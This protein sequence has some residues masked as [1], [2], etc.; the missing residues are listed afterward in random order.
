MYNIPR[1]ELE[2]LEV[3]AQVSHVEVDHWK[4]AI[5]EGSSK[6]VK[7]KKSRSSR[8]DRGLQNLVC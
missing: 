6:L 3:L 5:E 8:E 7:F 4:R 1:M 2:S